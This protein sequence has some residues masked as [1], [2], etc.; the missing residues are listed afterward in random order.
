V[1][2]RGRVR[3]ETCPK[4]VRGYL[5][6]H[7]VCDTV[8]A[9]YVWEKPVYPAHY[10]PLQDV[11]AELRPSGELRRSPSRGDAEVHDVLLAGHVAERAALVLLDSPVTELQR[12]A[13]FDWS[14]GLDWFEE[15]EPVHTHPRDPYTRVDVL[16]S[17]RRVRIS[18]EGLLVAQSSS[19]RILFETRLP[20]RY[21]L[22]APDVR[23]DL[24]VA[25]PKVTSCP[26]KGR[27]THWSL[28][29]STGMRDDLAWTYDSPSQEVAKVAGL[30]CFY[31]ER[32]DVELDGV[33]QARPS[34][35]FS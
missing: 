11:L 12:S 24:L 17:S 7:L 27:A 13:R 10:V 20:P 22:P 23:M 4:R 25:S 35:P 2:T 28:P 29:T 18:V 5:A 21:Y 1:T 31:D 8:R 9:L 3:I 14:A 34:T 19:P 6:G 30:V 32:V 26:Y 15:D 16:A 33:L